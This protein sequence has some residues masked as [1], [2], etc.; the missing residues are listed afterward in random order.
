MRRLPT[1]DDDRGTVIPLILIFTLIASLLLLVVIDATALFMGSRSIAAVADG[2]ALAA[3]QDI[4]KG[5]IYTT[6]GIK[7]SDLPIDAA[8]Q[9]AVDKYV[10]DNNVAGRFPGF[11]GATAVVDPNTNRVTVTITATVQ[12]PFVS[13]FTTHPDQTLATDGIGITESATAVLRCGEGAGATCG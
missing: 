4:D 3:A 13:W 10:A 12:L 5:T 8:A 11:Q 1:A 9:Q 2:A 7:G 6:G